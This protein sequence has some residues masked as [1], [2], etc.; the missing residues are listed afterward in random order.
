MSTVFLGGALVAAAVTLFIL[1]PI[2]SGC[3]LLSIGPKTN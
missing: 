2:L 3:M 1:Q